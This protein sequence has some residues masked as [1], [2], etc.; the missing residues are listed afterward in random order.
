MGAG[1]FFCR[2]PEAV[3]RAFHGEISFMPQKTCG[4]TD[5]YTSSVQ[6]SRRFIGL[7]LFLA[8]AQHGESG[9]AE[10][11]EHQALMGDVLRESLKAAGWRVLNTTPLPL[12]CFSRDRLDTSRFL[13]ALHERQVA[14]MSEVALGGSPALRACITSFRTTE[15][16][17]HWVVREMEELFRIGEAAR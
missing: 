6:W 14:W 16:H 3:A 13:A 10:M 4:A 9:Y 1:M 8:L 7:K 12:V 17:I 11:I 5:P 2:H 15:S